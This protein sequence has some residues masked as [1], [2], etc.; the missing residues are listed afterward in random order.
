[1]I[2]YTNNI[3]KAKWF[4]AIRSKYKILQK[5]LSTSNPKRY[6]KHL[7]KKA[8]GGE[9]DF[10]ALHKN[11]NLLLIE[12]KH[13]V[14][15][16]GIYLAPIQ[17]GMYY[18]LFKQL[19]N[20]DLNGV[21]MRVLKQ[22]QEIGLINPD[23]PP[24][25]KINELVPVLIVSEYNAKSSAKTKYSEVLRFIRQGRYEGKSFLKN[26]ETYNYTSARGIKP[27]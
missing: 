15:T 12:Y 14:N 21:V 25:S 11:G 2:G 24:P 8:L 20:K 26:V 16:S 10:L 19:P 27:W 4:G 1:M 18:D 13:G 7:E 3:E 9:L 5:A 6:G 17:I 22:K 23:W